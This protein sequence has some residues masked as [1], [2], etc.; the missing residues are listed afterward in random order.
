MQKI[1]PCLWF[2]NN[3]EEAV[4]LYAS[5]FKEVSIHNTTYYGEGGPAKPGS[6]M[7]IAFSL[8]GQNFLALNGGP[9]FQFNESV[10]FIVNCDSQEEIDRYWDRLTE[11]GSPSR[12]GWLKDRFGLSWQI[13]PRKMG[14][15]MQGPPEQS[16]KVMQE[17]MKMDKLDMVRLEKAYQEG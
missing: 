5:I 6:V 2:D 1:T 8:F 15:W 11:G 7:T 14:E 17:L 13:V 3:A 12:C 4:Q 9:V 16:G 10:S